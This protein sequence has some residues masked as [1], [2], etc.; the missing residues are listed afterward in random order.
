MDVIVICLTFFR[1]YICEKHF[2]EGR[3]FKTVRGRAILQKGVVPSQFL[4]RKPE[5]KPADQDDILHDHCYFFVSED[6]SKGKYIF[7]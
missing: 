4:R 2:I 1:F 7:L 3:D 5:S 6:G